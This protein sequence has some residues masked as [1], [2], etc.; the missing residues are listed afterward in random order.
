V[1]LGAVQTSRSAAVEPVFLSKP[2]GLAEQS[3]R[4]TARTATLPNGARHLGQHDTSK[5]P[6]KTQGVD[7]DQHK[8]APFLRGN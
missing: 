1:W 7:S 5:Q 2:L 8:T 6:N 3:F 4:R